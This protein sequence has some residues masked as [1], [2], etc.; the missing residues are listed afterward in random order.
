MCTPQ[1][2]SPAVSPFLP[3]TSSY[4]ILLIPFISHHF[5]HREHAIF[6]SVF[7]SASR[8]AMASRGSEFSFFPVLCAVSR[9]THRLVEQRVDG[10]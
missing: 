7:Y 3:T 6:I 10:G 8:M 5:M 4:S 1:I 2:K 9:T